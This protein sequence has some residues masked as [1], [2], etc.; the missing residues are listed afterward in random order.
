MN[1]VIR[2]LGNGC[3]REREYDYRARAFFAFDDR[4]NCARATAAIA[5]LAASDV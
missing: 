5:E 4:E 1:E 2:Y 3:V